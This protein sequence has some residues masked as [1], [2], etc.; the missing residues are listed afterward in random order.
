[1]ATNT[2]HLRD[3]RMEFKTTNDMKDLLNQAAIL[4]GMDLTSFVLGAA[5]EKARKV[6][7]EHATI[8]LTQQGQATLAQILANPGKPTKAMKDLMALP[9]LPTRSK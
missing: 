6:I 5:G 4:D 7:S 2:L 3:A 1:M 9:D 8:T